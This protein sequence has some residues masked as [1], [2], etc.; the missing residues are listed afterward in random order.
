MTPPLCLQIR[1]KQKGDV[2]IYG[3]SKNTEPDAKNYQSKFDN[4]VAKVVVDLPRFFSNTYF[5]SFVSQSGVELSVTPYFTMGA[6]AS[7][8]GPVRF[9]R[10]LGFARKEA[11]TDV[12]ESPM[13]RQ[14]LKEEEKINELGTGDMS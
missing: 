14:R 11:F 13:A 6:G 12:F 8:D 3:S 1:Y 10:S 9:E 4:P 5:F 7:K 2:V